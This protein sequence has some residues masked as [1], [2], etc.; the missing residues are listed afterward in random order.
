MFFMSNFTG[1]TTGVAVKIRITGSIESL[2][3]QPFSLL[4][5]LFVC[6]C[7]SVCTVV[8][9][10]SVNW[11]VIVIVCLV[12][13]STK[14]PSTFSCQC[15]TVPVTCWADRYFISFSLDNYWITNSIKKSKQLK[16]LDERW[17]KQSEN[18][19]GFFY[20]VLLCVG[21]S[22][23]QFEILWECACENVHPVK[24]ASLDQDTDDYFK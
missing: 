23:S 2:G 12:R 14:S 6:P 13:G 8:Y 19:N 10:E 20:L 3:N 7:V 4:S 9:I 22:L 21:V 16:E 18:P 15:E 24:G 1:P 11:V 5:L 17:I